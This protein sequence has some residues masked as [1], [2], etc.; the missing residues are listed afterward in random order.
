MS[1]KEILFENY[2]YN[3]PI[4][5][6]ELKHMDV[7]LSAESLRR[8]LNRMVQNEELQRFSNGVYF[9]T[10]WN[11]VLKQNSKLSERLVVER[12]YIRSGDRVYGYL[13]GLAFANQL[14]ITTQV[15]QHLEIVT[16]KTASKRRTIQLKSYRLTLKS[17]RV[18]VTAQNVKLLQILDL[19]SETEIY[20]EV[21]TQTLKRKA[22]SYLDD[23]QLSSEIIRT[24]VL[25]YPNKTA[26]R[27]MELELDHVLI[28]G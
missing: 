10:K 26:K 21:D 15:P 11:S 28:R 9:F 22:F 6:N 1:L 24:I 16:E 12:K 8:N 13:S 18:P 19:L 23:L 25:N 14:G 2:G 3:E 4:I 27:L 17:P 5:A 7:N 20:A